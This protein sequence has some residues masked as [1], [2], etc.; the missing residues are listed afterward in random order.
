[1]EPSTN[2]FESWTGAIA[3]PISALGLS[4]LQK[5]NQPLSW[6]TSTSCTVKSLRPIYPRSGQPQINLAVIYPYLT[7]SFAKGLP[8]ANLNGCIVIP[9]HTA[10]QRAKPCGQGLF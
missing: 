8:A 5:S 6:Q 7:S 1:M 9:R 10:Y 3:S 2:K 4:K